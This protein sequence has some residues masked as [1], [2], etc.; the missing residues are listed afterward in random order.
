MAYIFSLGAI[1][2]KLYYE[3][4]KIFSLTPFDNL[5]IPRAELK[6]YS[7]IRIIFISCALGVLPALVSIIV[8]AFF[9][10]VSVDSISLRTLA[11]VFAIIFLLTQLLQSLA[12]MAIGLIMSFSDFQEVHGYLRVYATIASFL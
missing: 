10:E 6:M 11:N 4:V 7:A 3:I 2:F 5:F 9:A 12:T 8:R 1:L